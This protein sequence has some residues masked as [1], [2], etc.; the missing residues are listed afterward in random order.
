M[1]LQKANSETPT[2]GVTLDEPAGFFEFANSLDVDYIFFRTENYIESEPR[3]TSV[4][5]CFIVNDNNSMIKSSCNFSF[6]GEE[7]VRDILADFI[8]NRN[9]NPNFIKGKVEIIGS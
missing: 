4:E 5:L 3:K 7:N 8:S 2:L 6:K 1:T 9:Y